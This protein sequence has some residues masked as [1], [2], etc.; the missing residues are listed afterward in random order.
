MLSERNPAQL[1]SL[2]IMHELP[3]HLLADP[4]PEL[5]Y[6][7]FTSTLLNL[8]RYL[9]SSDLSGPLETEQVDGPDWGGS[10][11]VSNVDLEL[12]KRP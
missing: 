1:R 9:I 7:F 10:A 12:R 8:H 3:D 4:S 5:L 11:G 2:S 6:F